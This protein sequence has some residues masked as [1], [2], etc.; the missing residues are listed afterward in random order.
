MSLLR[1]VSTTLRSGVSRRALLAPR[2]AT[3]LLSTKASLPTIEDARAMPRHVS[4]MS[5]DSLFVLAEGSGHAG[6][7]RERMRRE[8]MVV[9]N[10]DY[11]ATGTRL[12]EM[13]SL[14]AS[15]HALYKSPYQIGIFSALV[16]GWFSLPLVFHYQ[17]A[18]GF[19]DLFV[20]CDPPDVGEADTWLEVGAWSW[21]WMEPPLGTISFFLLCMQFAREQ[22]E[23]IG[24]KHFTEKIRERQGDS[25]VSAYPQYDEEIV[26]AYAESIALQSDA[27]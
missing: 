5:G 26:R 9:D 7:R 3:S 11:V 15:R 27:E 12:S 19:N 10:V 20:T 17:S 4:D 2:A 21:N 22:R 13:S 14:A 23:R 6:A 1:T 25:L 24:V 8:I 16:G 18:S